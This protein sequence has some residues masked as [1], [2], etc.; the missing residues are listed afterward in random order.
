MI[1]TLLQTQ[2]QTSS[3]S[4][5]P[6]VPV[7]SWSASYFRVGIAAKLRNLDKTPRSGMADMGNL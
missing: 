3:F 7:D 6:Y 5:V 4:I 2:V 1:D